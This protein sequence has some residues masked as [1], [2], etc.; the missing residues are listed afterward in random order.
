MKRAFYKRK[1]FLG[2]LIILAFIV[3]VFWDIDLAASWAAFTK[4]E[5]LYFVPVVLGLL[6]VPLA[7]AQRLKFIMDPEKHV[8]PW[9]VFEVYNVAQ[10]LNS[11][12]PAVG[13]VAR[14]LFFARIFNLPKTFAFTVVML[15]VLFDAI[16]LV[17]LIFIVSTIAVMPEWLLRSELAIF[18][19]TVLL[20]I[21]CYYVLHRG[22]KSGNWA[23]RW[24]H[25]L[26]E[27]WVNTWTKA[28]Q[29]MVAGLRMLKSWRHLA[30][31]LLFSV[32]F[33]MARVFI[34]FSLLYAFQFDVPFWGAI[35]VLVMLS[36]AI[37]VQISPGNVGTFQF[38][39]ILGLS[40]YGVKKEAA[41][42]FSLVLHALEMLTVLTLGFFSS[43]HAAI[44]LRELP[45]ADEDD[46]DIDTSTVIAP[47]RASRP[48]AAAT[49][50]AS[51]PEEEGDAKYLQPDRPPLR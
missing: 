8:G 11:F 47:D 20:F 1:R 18:T 9:R 44:R 10:M 5:P 3:Y 28:M 6:L 50:E 30:R 29:S 15:E 22:E 25:R 41:L 51:S 42:S 43:V 14:V 26:P 45:A 17:L 12:V 39:C 48:E 13:P 46:N 16:T 27:S 2:A 7:R 33:W 23:P 34:V 19:A 37:M 49:P 21:F 40:L 24:M 36:I 38:A 32:I 31:V 35:V 4:I